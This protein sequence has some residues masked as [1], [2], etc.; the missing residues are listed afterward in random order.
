[1]H[2]EPKTN[3]DI[4]IILS[5]FID[6][7]VLKKLKMKNNMSVVVFLLTQFIMKTQ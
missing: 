3:Y 7:N 5:C 6:E 4:L 2:F 1:M